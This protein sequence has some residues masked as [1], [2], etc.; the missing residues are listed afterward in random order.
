MNPRDPVEH[1]PFAPPTTEL[2]Y[3]SRLTFGNV[4][5][6]PLILTILLSSFSPIL[7]LYEGL[8]HPALIGM[9]ILVAPIFAAYTQQGR[10]RV[11]A[12]LISLAIT[13]V[14]TVGGALFIFLLGGF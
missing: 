1:N 3:V 8:L 13:C 10:W 2:N 11:V 14:F 7:F 12:M 4:Q 5:F 6:G 9:G